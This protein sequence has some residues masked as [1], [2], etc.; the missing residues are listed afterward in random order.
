MIDNL[1]TIMLVDGELRDFGVFGVA[2]CG[3][4]VNNY[5]IHAH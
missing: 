4:D 3:F 5:K 2:T 1:L